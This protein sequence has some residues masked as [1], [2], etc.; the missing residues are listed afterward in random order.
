MVLAQQVVER[1]DLGE[2]DR[3]TLLGL[4]DQLSHLCEHGVTPGQQVGLSA[5][6]LNVLRAALRVVLEFLLELL[7]V[8]R[9]LN[10][11][12]EHILADCDVLVAGVAGSDVLVS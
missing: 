2:V 5:E 4:V 6:L 11:L 8:L 3:R 9:A 1:G 12:V 10:Q 7:H